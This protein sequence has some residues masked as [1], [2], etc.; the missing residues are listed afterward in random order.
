EDFYNDKIFADEQ[1]RS[2]GDRQVLKGPSYV[3]DVK[4]A[5]WFTHAGGPGNGWD[6]GFRVVLEVTEK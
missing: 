1:P 2:S 4:N 5:T 3:G 6:V